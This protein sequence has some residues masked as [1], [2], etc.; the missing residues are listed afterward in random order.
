MQ[1][2]FTG[3]R[4][5]SSLLA[6]EKVADRL[7]SRL[8]DFGFG[9]AFLCAQMALI[10]RF[11]CLGL[12]ALGAAIGKAGLVRPKFELFTANCTDFDRKR[13]L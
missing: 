5:D 10:R 7:A 2:R 9:F 13:H 6:V 12:R 1:P 8:V 4:V 3:T 11:C